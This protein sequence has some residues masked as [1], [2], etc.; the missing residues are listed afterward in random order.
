MDEEIEIK[1][2]EKINLIN[3]LIKK[4]KVLNISNE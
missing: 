4:G 2:N 3:Y 1:K